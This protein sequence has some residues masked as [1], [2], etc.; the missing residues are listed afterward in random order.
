MACSVASLPAGSRITAFISLGVI[1]KTFPVGK[2]QA[3]LQATG[4]ASVRKRDLPAHLMVF[5]VIAMVL[6]MQSPLREVLRCLLEG[7]QWLFGPAVTA[8]V[9]SK[10]AISRARARLDRNLCINSMMSWCGRS[11]S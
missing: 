10:A 8:K 2:V 3:V 11:R 5:Y 4:K 9:A 6:F 7:L 1:A